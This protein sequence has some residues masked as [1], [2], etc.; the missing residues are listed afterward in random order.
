MCAGLALL[1]RAVPK[2]RPHRPLACEP[3]WVSGGHG[4]QMLD[5]DSPTH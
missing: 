1:G 3:V 5:A 2:S 4:R